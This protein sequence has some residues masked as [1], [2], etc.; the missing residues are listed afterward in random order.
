MARGRKNTKETGS[1]AG[2]CWP[3]REGVPQ[4]PEK[5]E[6]VRLGVEEDMFV[7]VRN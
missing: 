4:A 2:G 3:R 1:S 7:G 5:G 6:K